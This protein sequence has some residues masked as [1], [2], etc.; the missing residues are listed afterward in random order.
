MADAVLDLGALRLTAGEGRRLDLTVPLE[1]VVLGGEAYAPSPAE[2]TVALEVSRMVGGG[3]A[4][5]VRLRASLHGPCVRCLRPAA[6]EVEADA[7]ELDDPSAHDE[8]LD[9]PYLVGEDLAV[10]RW[11]QDAF[12]LALPD[13]VVCREDCPGLCPQCG[14]VLD[15]HPGH[16]HEREP[17]NRWAKLAELDLG[18]AAQE[19]ASEPSAP[20]R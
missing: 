9:S 16:A 14:V 3:Y 12:V 8:Q 18:P 7:R 20:E 17:D 5:R 15:E 6:P 4:M 19:P 13:Q 11:A 1:D 10:G 2:P